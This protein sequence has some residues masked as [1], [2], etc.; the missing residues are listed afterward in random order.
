MTKIKKFV[1]FA[2]LLSALA[3]PL[4][5]QG[6]YT[7]ASCNWSDVN[8][9]I[10]GPTHT[11]VT[12]D[13]ILIPAGTCTWTSTLSVS[14]NITLQGT[15]TPNTLPG[16]F[17]AGTLN[18]VIVDDIPSAGIIQ[19]QIT[20]SPG[21]LLRLSTLDIEPESA[22]TALTSPIQLAGTCTSSGCPSIRIDNI[23]LGITTSWTTNN[24]STGN[25]AWLI[26][27]DN[28]FG[29]VDH[30]SE[31]TSNWPDFL[32]VELSAYLGVGGYGDNSWAQP[33]TF[34]TASAL[35]VENN[36][37]Y[38]Q[39]AVMDTEIAPANGGIGGGR[40][41]ARFN[42]VTSNNG[43]GMFGNHGLETNG[44]P[45]GGRQTEVYG[46][47]VT[48]ATGSSSGCNVVVGY[49]S[50][51]GFIFGNTIN[52]GSGHWF[53]SVVALVT[54]R[55]VFNE[56]APWGACGGSSAYDTNDGTVYVSGT[57][58]STS[59]GGTSLTPIV[60]TDSSKSWTTNE[61]APNGAPY[62]F[63]DVTKGFWMQIASNT[64]NALTTQS[65]IPE[66]EY[67]ASSGDSYEILRATVCA[68][69]P[70]RGKGNYVSGSS[71]TPSG[72][73]DQAID[74][75]YE[76]DDTAGLLSCSSSPCNVGTGDSGQTI[77]N[78]D[79]YTDGS[80]GSPQA[81][82]SP[83]SPFNG[84]TGVGFGTLANRPTTCT[85]GVGYFATDQ[86]SWNT[87]GN[88]FGN[89]VLYQCSTPNSWI[90]HYTPYNY[91][92]PLT[93]GT[94]NTAPAPPTNLVTTLE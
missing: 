29:V 73:L 32:D 67:T 78:R 85:P 38:T 59:G 21:A 65:P 72:A 2:L 66:G 12:G 45:Q 42:Q 77:A 83:T 46:N 94:G 3:A 26:R 4:S 19:A 13:V 39:T 92:H 81:Q 20:Y 35:Y 63:Y 51:T 61:W 9:V 58:T 34:G 86:G 27:V 79:W 52:D 90:V 70:G 23:G 54:Y 37:L 62:S 47:T 24:D 68:D 57:L 40:Y 91:P 89:G 93:Q 41:V 82:T 15:G 44:R 64:G 30:N 16:Q 25:C 69:Q 8:A 17:G 31:G 53:N 18:T 48:C 88:K 76:W 1:L 60:A 74:P 84:I 7:A 50:G 22:T 33:D 6:T 80:N 14:V 43:F 56:A 71:P 11:A 28:S 36:V 49:R 10:N 75:V 87:S 5:A 55:T